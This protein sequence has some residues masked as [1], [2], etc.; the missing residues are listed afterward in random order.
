[1]VGVAVNVSGGG[2]GDDAGILGR[3]RAKLEEFSDLVASLLLKTEAWL[4]QQ[5][6]SQYPR[7]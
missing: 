3:S 4:L 6:W 1:M 5:G 7:A 2:G